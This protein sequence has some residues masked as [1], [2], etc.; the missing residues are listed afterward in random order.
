MD[1][2]TDG[3]VSIGFPPTPAAQNLYDTAKSLLGKSLYDVL[4]PTVPEEYGC[5]ASL[6]FVLRAAGYK[7]PL[8]GIDTVNG[9]IAWLLA[10]GWIEQSA[11]LP[12][13]VITAHSPEIAVTTGAHTGLCLI[14]GVG[15]NNSATGIFDEHF[16]SYQMWNTEFSTEGSVTRYFAPPNATPSSQN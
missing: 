3:G 13:Y 9:I 16:S 8:Q 7:I 1:E 11:P 14:Y 6:S 4:N 2:S 5:A 12:G 15:S 10:N